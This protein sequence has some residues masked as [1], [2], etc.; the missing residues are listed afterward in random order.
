M[1][2]K[3]T[4]AIAVAKP[5][6]IPGYAEGPGAGW[7]KRRRQRVIY[8]DPVQARLIGVP[9]TTQR[10]ALLGGDLSENGLM[11]KSPELFPV[12]SRLLLWIDVAEVGEPIRIVGRVIWVAR[13]DRQERFRMGVQFETPS[14]LARA[15]LQQLV[16]KRG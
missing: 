11:L 10:W 13:D 1:A 8:R 7:D 9:K 5:R 16:A 15:Q 14:N 4:Q 6:R 2:L 12:R 3:K